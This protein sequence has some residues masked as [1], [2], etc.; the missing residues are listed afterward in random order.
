MSNLQKWINLS[1]V[2]RQFQLPLSTILSTNCTSYNSTWS[3]KQFVN[4]VV[5][6]NRLFCT[7]SGKKEAYL[8]NQKDTVKKELQSYIEQKKKKLR[9][10]EQKLKDRGNVLLKDIEK[11]KQKVKERVE[12]IVEV[13]Y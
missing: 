4:Y 12:G 10:T 9:V 3:N 11:T 7:T 13:Q 5:Y 6:G 1:R 8:T 2:L